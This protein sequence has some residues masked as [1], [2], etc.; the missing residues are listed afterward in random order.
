MPLYQ[1]IHPETEEVVEVVQRMKED[2]V[3][4]D[5]NGIEWKRVWN[6]PQASM[7][8]QVDPFS[9]KAF[10][11]STD[12]KNM[13]VGDMWDKSKEMSEL[14]A[15]RLGTKDPVKEKYESDARKL[16]KGKQIRES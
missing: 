12:S 3:Y 8:T 11:E 14:R 9:S 6:I 4:I 16:R 7:D 2:H 13:T 10:R 15:H 1:F 5:E